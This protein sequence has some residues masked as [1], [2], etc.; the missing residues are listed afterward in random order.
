M[1]DKE[2]KRYCDKL[3]GYVNLS[4]ELDLNLKPSDIDRVIRPALVILSSRIFN[5]PREK[6]L[7]LA[8]IVQM[9]Y[10]ASRIH[11]LFFYIKDKKITSK[12]RQYSVLLGDYIY[13]HSYNLLNKSG[14]NCFLYQ[15][16]KIIDKMSEG[17][18]ISV[19]NPSDEIK[20]IR[21][22]SA[23]FFSRICIMGASLGEAN[24]NERELLREFGYNVGMIYGLNEKGFKYEEKK[25]Y[26]NTALGILAKIPDSPLKEVMKQLIYI[27][28]GQNLTT[29]WS[30]YFTLPA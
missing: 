16:A 23:E 18:V 30:R 25:E 9:V 14:L 17:G 8:C 15:M 10:F 7:F 26:V 29:V 13:S 5:G 4:R 22:E 2:L 11:S 27:C 20:I 1:V 3:D 6:T 21:K 24:V 28:A 12:Q 19:L